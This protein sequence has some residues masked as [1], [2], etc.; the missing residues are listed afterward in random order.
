L[1]SKARIR[2]V[3]DGLFVWNDA[4]KTEAI[5]MHGIPDERIV[6]TGAQCFDQWF[7]RGPTR[8]REDF[9][10]RARLP[11]EQPYVLWVCSAL[12]PGSPP[13]SDLVMRWA[14]HL[15]ASANARL[16]EMPILI[17][18]HPSRLAE[19]A[20]FDWDRIGRIAFFGDNPTDD[21]TRADYFDSLYHSAAVVGITTTAFIEAA[22]VGRPVMTIFFDD[23]RQEHE[24]SLHFQLLLNVA[25]GVMIVARSLEE[26]EHQL[27]EMID[28]PPQHVLE[29]QRRFVEAFVR[30]HGVAMSATSVMADALERIGRSASVMVPRRASGWGRL[31]LRAATA[32]ERH[33]R[34]RYLVLDERE[35]EYAA[36]E[37]EKDRLRQEALAR[38]ALQRAEKARR[39]ERRSR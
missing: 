33:P 15:R 10:R 32:I 3:P 12:L 26:H 2:D 6:V 27:S 13:E 11:D 23:V 38:K 7:G 20:A 1:S 36:R 5:E 28:G 22:I 14:M 8:S 31:G 34:W 4:Q 19:W 35:A 25:G 17:R 30:P 18:P 9:I 16:R 37:S 39:A 29:Q 24:G 21:E